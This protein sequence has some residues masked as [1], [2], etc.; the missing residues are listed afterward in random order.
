MTKN[1]ISLATSLLLILALAVGG[2]ATTG[3]NTGMDNDMSSG[4]MQP[5][6]MEK[7]AMA[8]GA[9]AGS[10]MMN[11][12]KMVSPSMA[13]TPAPDMEESGETMTK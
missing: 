13:T 12:Q 11:E 7:N 10:G 4:N 2:C 9:D 6:T 8:T 1:L 5:R 3:M